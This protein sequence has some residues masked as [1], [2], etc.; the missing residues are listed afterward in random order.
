MQQ[1][2]EQVQLFYDTWAKHH[3]SPSERTVLKAAFSQT[4]H[5]FPPSDRSLILREAL[6]E[7][8]VWLCFRRESVLGAVV[9]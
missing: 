1:I 5:A 6:K 9:L 8:T 4:K 2:E 3:F 7:I